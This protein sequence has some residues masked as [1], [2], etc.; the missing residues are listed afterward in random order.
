MLFYAIRLD[1]L[2]EKGQNNSRV[3]NEDLLIV[4]NKITQVQ[5]V[6]PLLAIPPV[7]NIS[8]E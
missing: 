7:V 8:F 6:S 1:S 3:M 5:D 4:V 2:L